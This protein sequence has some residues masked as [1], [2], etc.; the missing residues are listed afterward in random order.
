MQTDK[1]VGGQHYKMPIQPIE[2]IL[3]NSLGYIEGN[4]IKYV[5][6]YKNKG[7]VEDLEKSKH[8][9]EMLIESLTPKEQPES[10]EFQHTEKDQWILYRNGVKEFTGTY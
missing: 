2:F 8:Y 10:W 6:R 5:C 9:L 4:I 7:G 3:K 1:Q